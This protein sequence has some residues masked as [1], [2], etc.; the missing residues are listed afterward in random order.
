MT[1]RKKGKDPR[2]ASKYLEDLMDGPLTL[3]SARSRGAKPCGI[4]KASWNI[5]GASL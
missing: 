1:A 5:Q 3:G 4:C 2:E